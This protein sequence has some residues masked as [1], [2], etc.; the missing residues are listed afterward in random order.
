M[1]SA[2]NPIPV[3][4]IIVSLLLVAATVMMYLNHRSLQ[5]Q[6]RQQKQ[7]FDHELERLGKIDPETG[8]VSREWFRH[9]LDTEC[10]RAVRELAPLTIMRLHVDLGSEP[11]NTSLL[12]QIVEQV[13][14]M[15]SRPGDQVGRYDARSIGLLLPSTN[16]HAG[17]FADRCVQLLQEKFGNQGVRFTLAGWTLQP[18]AELTAIKALERLDALYADAIST[19]PG[20]VVYQVEQADALTMNYQ[21]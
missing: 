16:E 21:L 9:L 1:N 12:S 14:Q 6:L 15:I 19:S 10:R 20:Q 5:R 4:A 13:N 18:T 2:L 7:W 11:V 3:V 17:R 8:A